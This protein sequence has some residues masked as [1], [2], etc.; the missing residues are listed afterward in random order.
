MLQYITHTN[1]KINYI[2]GA[3]CALKGGCKWIQLRMKNSTEAEIIEV[4]TKLKE[5]CKE[6]EAIFVIDDHVDITLKCDVDGVHLGKNDMP[7]AE[8]RAVLG[9]KFIIGGTANSC[10]DIDNLVKQGVDYIGLGPFRHTTTKDKLSPI[11]GLE[12]YKLIIEHCKSKGYRTPIVAIGGITINDI[13][14]I[15][16]C[17]VSG[18]ALSGT[19]LNAD[20]PIEETENILKTL[21]KIRDNE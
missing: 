4:A 3:I 18:I 6:Y 5:L 19:I 9:E 21:Y 1:S 15:M 13:P 17:G 20:N 11:L 14:A 10:E 16:D 12:G 2:E 8:A 7:P